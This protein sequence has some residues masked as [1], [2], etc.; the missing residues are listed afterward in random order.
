MYR[1]E[2]I[3]YLSVDEVKAG[4]LNNERRVLVFQ[5]NRFGKGWRPGLRLP[6]DEDAARSRVKVTQ[7]PLQMDATN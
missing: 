4:G 1:G 3:I 6:S 7:I 2:L 5:L